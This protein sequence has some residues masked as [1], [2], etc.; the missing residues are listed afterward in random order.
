M[1]P[2]IKGAFCFS[3]F[4]HCSIHANLDIQREIGVTLGVTVHAR[5]AVT[6][7]R[8]KPLVLTDIKAKSA[9]AK[10][11]PYKLTDGQGLYL[12]VTPDRA[13]E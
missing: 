10:E 8:R 1:S 13:N 4:V 7:S 9:K 11:K 6:P 12:Q 2:L 3:V 5:T